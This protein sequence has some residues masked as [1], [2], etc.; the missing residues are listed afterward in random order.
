MSD[1]DVMSSYWNEIGAS[2]KVNWHIAHIDDDDE[3]F[4]SGEKSLHLIFDNKLNEIVS[5]SMVLDV[6]CGRGRV[7]RALATKRPD[8]RVFG[9][10][11]APSMI[12]SAIDANKDVNNLSF[13]VCDGTSLSVF[14]DEVFNFIYSFIVFQ[15]LPRHITGQYISDAARILKPGGKFI[16]QVQQKSEIMAIDPPWDD[17]RTIRYYTEQQIVALVK[18]PLEV[19]RTR[20]GGITFLWNVSGLNRFMIL[21]SLWGFYDY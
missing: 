16:F 13:C 12:K 2:S 4:R 6:G 21:C 11:V 10:D 19:M 14:P 1:K 3:F 5:G 17:F 15:H 7:A 9:V 18:S 8:I 20:G